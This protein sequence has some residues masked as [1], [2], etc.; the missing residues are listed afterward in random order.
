[1][2]T[3]HELKTEILYLVRKKKVRRD[4]KAINVDDEITFSWL[5]DLQDAI[6]R[7]QDAIVFVENNPRS[8]ILGLYNCIMRETSGTKIKCVFLMDKAPKFVSSSEFYNT[9]LNKGFAINVYKNNQWGTFRHMP[10]NKN[11][12]HTEC[13]FLDT[14][15]ADQP[16]WIEKASISEAGNCND[17]VIVQVKISTL[18]DIIIIVLGYNCSI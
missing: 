11:L 18:T 15:T 12:I 7:D 4:V 1:M 2:L 6:S 3:V 5:P 17:N 14:K 8:G 16:R 10:L 13:Y 9:Q